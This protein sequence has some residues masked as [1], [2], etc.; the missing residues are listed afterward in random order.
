VNAPQAIATALIVAGVAL[1]V[2]ARV[3]GALLGALLIALGAGY[4]GA[5]LTD[6]EK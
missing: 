2:T 5:T 3:P 1:V 4:L 6:D